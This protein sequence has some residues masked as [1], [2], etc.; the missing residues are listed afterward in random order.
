M[1]CLLYENQNKCHKYDI[2]EIHITKKSVSICNKNIKGSIYVANTC[3]CYFQA[4]VNL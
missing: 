2:P 1:I 3:R 4:R